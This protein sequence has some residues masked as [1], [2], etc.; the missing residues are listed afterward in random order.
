M[1]KKKL[2]DDELRQRKEAARKHGAYSVMRHGEQALDEQG[3][4]YLAEIREK[5]QTREGVLLL[6]QERAATAVLVADMVTSF[7]TEE[8]KAGIPLEEINS[9]RALPAF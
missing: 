1:S 3:I 4:S 9:L 7:V 8:A 5:V 6:M 2:S